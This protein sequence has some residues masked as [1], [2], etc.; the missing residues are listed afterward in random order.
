MNVKEIDWVLWTTIPT[1]RSLM[2]Q[3]VS[4]SA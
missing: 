3:T 2:M 1:C 4:L